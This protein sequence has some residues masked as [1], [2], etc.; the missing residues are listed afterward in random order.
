MR[1]N[2]M[3]ELISWKNKKQRQPLLLLGARQVGKT[4]LL[5]EL[6]AREFDDS[7]YINLERDHT[8]STLFEENLNP[9]RI[10]AE[11]EYLNNK[12]IIPGK[13]LLI[14][15]EIQLDMKVITSLKYFAE[16]ASEYHVVGAG[17][18]LDVALER[19]NYSF[20]V[21]KVEF[22]YLYPF[23]FDEFLMGLGQE[24][25]LERIEQSYRSLEQMPEALHTKLLDLYKRYLFVGGMPAAINHYLSVGSDIMAFDRMVQE[26]I[27]N[28]YI[29]DMSK[30]T[31]SNQVIKVQA[32]YR[33][34]PKQLASD[35]RKFKYSVVERGAK[36]ATFSSS[37]EWLLL[38]K[39]GLE[40]Q[41]INRPEIPLAAYV[42]KKHFKLYM[43][44]VGLLMNMSR[45]PFSILSNQQE[46]NLFKGALT[47]N[48]VAQ[49]LR[50]GGNTLY[51]WKSKA[52]EVD[53]ILQDKDRIIPLEVKASDNTRSR[54]LMEY[55]RKFDS[56]YAIRL[57][58]KNF[59]YKNNIKSLPLYC[60]YLLREFA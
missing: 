14:F 59:G 50:A 43:S 29:A 55:M 31:S 8:I 51:Y 7:I 24:M 25:L 28:A 38:S 52:H 54:S 3:A 19:E 5:Q 4:Y 41:M 20:P 16:E 13:T 2:A 36:S 53:F 33:S 37:I 27:L 45:T 11:I 44:D 12:K 42:E 26:N 34:I 48:Y 32:I 46:H 6:A 40:C 17:S 22:L 23:T 10:I 60:T 30:Y 57:S 35:N 1:R 56:A 9:K 39:V 49:Q 58:T 21:G 47:E 18:L 15:D